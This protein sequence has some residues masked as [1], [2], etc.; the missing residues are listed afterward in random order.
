MNSTETKPISIKRFA[1]FCGFVPDAAKQS[2]FAAFEST[3]RS[4]SPT[5]RKL[6]AHIAELATRPHDSGRQVNAAY[7]PELHE[8][9]GLDPE[10]MFELLK[11]LESA[12]AIQIEGKYPYQDVLLAP[13]EGWLLLADLARFCAHEKLLLR[14]IVVDLKFDRLR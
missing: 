7:L 4:L 10:P 9:C 8:T 11:E 13:T 6:L 14:D 2:A 1:S 5:A 3:L 12:H